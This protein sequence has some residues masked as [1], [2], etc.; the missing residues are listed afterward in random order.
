MNDKISAFYDLAGKLN[1]RFSMIPLLYGSLG[2][3]TLVEDELSP[4]DIDISVPRYFYLVP[5]GW[6]ALRRLME[7]EGYELIDPHEHYFKRS[8]IEVNI[9][10]L[11]GEN[12]GGI[13]S[14]EEHAGLRAADF[15]I[16]TAGGAVF[17]LPTLEQYANIYEASRR[18]TYRR[19]RSDD[20]DLTKLNAIHRALEKSHSL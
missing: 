9:G 3:S 16:I 4:D 2:L 17:K 13:S 6:A 11:D 7:D 5:E 8:E 18:D 15:P 12:P 10:L 19:K 14:L 20:K 1:R